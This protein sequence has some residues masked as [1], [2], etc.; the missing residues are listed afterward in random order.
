[1]ANLIKV[2]DRFLNLDQVRTVQD[3]APSMKQNQLIVFFGSGEHDSL[4]FTGQD[5]ENLR[6]WLNSICN[7]LS[8]LHMDNDT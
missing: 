7:D 5:A 6:T 3:L 2:G 1:M 4:T 8:H